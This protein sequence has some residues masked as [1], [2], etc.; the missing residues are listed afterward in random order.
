MKRRSLSLF[1][2]AVFTAAVFIAPSAQAQDG[3]FGTMD[4]DIGR[5]GTFAPP[6]II[7]EPDAGDAPSIGASGFPAGEGIRDAGDAPSI[8]SEGI[9]AGEGERDAGDAPSIGE[10]S[11]IFD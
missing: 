7:A 4:G 9:P 11:N 5:D 8:G 10:A 2:A 3:A 1:S 6:G